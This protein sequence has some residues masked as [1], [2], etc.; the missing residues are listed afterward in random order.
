MLTF[1]APLVWLDSNEIYFPSDLGN[2][3]VNT[4]PELNYTDITNGPSPLTL[5]NLNALNALGGKDVYLSGND[6]WTAEPAWVLGVKPD[7]T[8]K[9]DGAVSC[10]VVVHD[11]G[12]GVVDAYYFYFYAY[13]VHYK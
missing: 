13:G 10:A 3:L 9:T 7:S 5:D 8:G 6:D 1:T 12:N 11:H 4:H 2:Q